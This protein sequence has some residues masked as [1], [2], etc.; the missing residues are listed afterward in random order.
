MQAIFGLGNPGRQYDYT[1]HNVGFAFMDYLCDGAWSACSKGV[2]GTT[3]CA[4]HTFFCVKPDTF[5]NA[6]GQC[7]G[8]FVQK[9]RIPLDKS[10]VVYD[11]AEVALGR[12]RLALGGGA[13]GHNG[14][15]SIMGTSGAGFWRL[16]I[17]VGRDARMDLGS[18]VLKKM[19]LKSWEVIVE[20]FVFVAEHMELLFAENV[21]PEDFV[22]RVNGR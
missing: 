9:H 20:T 2:Y 14:L 21:V 8:P 15:R 1:P 4:D 17:G 16:G 13:R 7:L 22:R 5:M 3:S 10:L 11:D 18:F 12:I 19:P 6:S